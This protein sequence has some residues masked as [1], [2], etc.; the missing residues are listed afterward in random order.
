MLSI[1]GV[2]A[3]EIDVVSSVVGESLGDAGYTGQM[4]PVLGVADME[5]S[6]DNGHIDDSPAGKDK[7]GSAHDGILKSIQKDSQPTYTLVYVIIG[8]AIVALLFY[9]GYMKRSDWMT[10]Y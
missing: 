6:A 7:S 3:E 2:S 5:V 4:N 8:I 1:N 10:D 9:S